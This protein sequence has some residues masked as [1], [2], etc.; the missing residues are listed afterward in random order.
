MNIDRDVQPYEDREI[1][2][3]IKHLDFYKSGLLSC[4]YTLNGKEENYSVNASEVK[5][6]ELVPKLEGDPL[7]DQGFYTALLDDHFNIHWLVKLRNGSVKYE[8]VY[9]APILHDQIHQR[10]IDND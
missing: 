9:A 2:I 4:D 7:D 8:A 3:E 5:F 10:I 1:N 6:F